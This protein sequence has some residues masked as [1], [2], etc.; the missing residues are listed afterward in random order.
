MSTPTP[1]LFQPTKLG[2]LSLSHRVVLAP[3]T[4]MRA[5]SRHVPSTLALDYYSQRASTPGTLLLTEATFISPQAGGY[6]HVPGAYTDDQLRVW[7]KITDAV[8]ERGSYIYL[9]LWA[10]GRS[11]DEANLKQENPSYDVVSASDIGLEGHAVPRPLTKEEIDVGV[12]F[13]CR[14]PG[15]D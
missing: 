4:R 14:R 11:A 3:L 8:H 12:H 10:L 13:E 2:K 9:Q 7:K 5:D 15:L 1:K 6:A